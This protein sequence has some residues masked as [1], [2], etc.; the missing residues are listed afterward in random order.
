MQEFD[1]LFN[2]TFQEGPKLKILA[3]IIIQS[4]Y[5]ISIDQ[6]DH[7]IKIIFCNIG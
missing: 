5:E 1:A 2:Y 4:K 6:T 7:I 3:I